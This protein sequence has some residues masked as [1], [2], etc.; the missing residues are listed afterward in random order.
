MSG[1]FGKTTITSRADRISDFQINS[2]T[3]GATVP[4]VLGTTRISG[5]IID[6]TDFTAY[7]HRHTQRSG[8]GGGVKSVSIDYTY[9]VAVAIALCA[10]PI[11]GIGKV[12]R[13]KEVLN[14]PNEGL[15]LSLFDGRNGQEPWSYM[16]GK[17][18]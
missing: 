15:G 7:E 9:T 3:Y 2:A 4:Q 18:P 11:Q 8:K 12:W 13:N 6:Y 16:K 5:N 10:G 14:Y 17:H 1:I